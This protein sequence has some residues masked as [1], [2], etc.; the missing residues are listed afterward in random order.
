MKVDVEADGCSCVLEGIP[1]H[2]NT[3]GNQFVSV[4]YRRDLHEQMTIGGIDVA[5]HLLLERLHDALVHIA[6]ARHQIA[7][8]GI[9]SRQTMGDQMTALVQMVKTQIGIGRLLPA[10][11]MD[12]RDAS[13]LLRGLGLRTS[14]RERAGATA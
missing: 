7:L 14:N 12:A 13:P 10:A 6:R 11:R 5:V 9:L 1:L 3:A 4:E 2:L 8:V